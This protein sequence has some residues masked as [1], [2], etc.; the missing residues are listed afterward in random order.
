LKEILNIF[1]NKDEFIKFHYIEV[2]NL[3]I[4]TKEEEEENK[5]YN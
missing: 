5:N 2:D 4:D 1:K 3:Y